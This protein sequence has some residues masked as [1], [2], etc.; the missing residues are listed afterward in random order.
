MIWDTGREYAAEF[1]YH[2]NI[3]PMKLEEPVRKRLRN[4]M[5]T[6]EVN[7]LFRFLTKI[8][9]PSVGTPKSLLILG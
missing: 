6:R 9:Y 1:A 2:T 7:R 4:E 5:F 8:D 3:E